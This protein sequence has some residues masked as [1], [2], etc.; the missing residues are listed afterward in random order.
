MKKS[1]GW[2]LV[3]WMSALLM[4]KAEGTSSAN[5]LSS[6]LPSWAPTCH[7]TKERAEKRSRFLSISPV[8]E[9]TT[10]SRRGRA[11]RSSMIGD[12]GGDGND[13]GGKQRGA[14][15]GKASV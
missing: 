4:L 10:E 6:T 11:V 9:I 13:R 8:A 5:V 3:N 1:S 15:A 7:A 14:R 12:L 2:N